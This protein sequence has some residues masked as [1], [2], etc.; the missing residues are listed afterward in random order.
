MALPPDH[1]Y[2]RGS[3]RREVL[4]IR[5][6]ETMSR[7]R[8]ENDNARRFGFNSDYQMKK[9]SRAVRGNDRVRDHL[10]DAREN[11]FSPAEFRAYAG[12]LAED[13]DR[14]QREA[15]RSGGKPS[16]YQDKSADGPLAN[17]LA[18]IGRRDFG[19]D[20]AVGDTPGTK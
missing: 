8:A 20:Y 7:A 5:T 16:D 4:N 12:K 11:G 14:A 19:A 18:A 6:G 3:G 15:E 2:V 17:Y 9:W 1:R 13:W 10:P